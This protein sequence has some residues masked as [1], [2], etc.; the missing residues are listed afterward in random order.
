MGSIYV[1]RWDNLPI[2]KCIENYKNFY[3]DLT[4]IN[5]KKIKENDSYSEDFDFIDRM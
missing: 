4:N 2:S 1:G 3:Y 5:I